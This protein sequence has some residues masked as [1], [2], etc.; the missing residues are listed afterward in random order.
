MALCS[1][2]LR[3][4]LIEKDALPKEPLIAA[5]P[6]SVR[7]GDEED[8]YQNRVSMLLADL[9][10]NEPDPVKRLRRVQQSMN[11]AKTQF[12]AIPA[13]TLQDY[14]QFAPPAIAARAM[15]MYSRLRIADRAAPPFN[16]IIS[17][18]PGPSMPL[19]S[20][21][22]QLLHFYP[23][24]AVTDGQGLNMTVQSYNGNLDFGFVVV[25]RAGARPVAAHRPPPGVDGRVP[26]PRRGRARRGAGRHRGPGEEGAAA[27]P[28]KKKTRAE[29]TAKKTAARRSTA[30]TTAR[31]P[32]PRRPPAKKACQKAAKKAPAKKTTARKSTARGP[33]R[34]RRPRRRW[35]PR[36]LPRPPDARR[37]DR[38]ARRRRSGCRGSRP[39]GTTTTRSWA[40]NGHA[41]IGGVGQGRP[42]AILAARWSVGT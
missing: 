18:V 10:S 17:N 27:R 5:V 11:K 29:S 42:A 22:A 26:R 1:S 23:I 12:A 32:P 33:R 38:A 34:G 6:V 13:D 15:R 3:R 20:A 25:P 30:K 4:Y 14:T 35:R 21:G 40:G 28:A 16:L 24:S 31:S 2:T 9:A 8:M 36:R 39:P 7:T 37:A 19:Y 41:Q